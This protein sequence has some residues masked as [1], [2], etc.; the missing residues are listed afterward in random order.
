MKV[1][2]YAV[3]LLDVDELRLCL[4]VDAVSLIIAPLAAV[5]DFEANLDDVHGEVLLEQVMPQ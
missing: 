5:C 4:R 3:L 2:L 1:Q